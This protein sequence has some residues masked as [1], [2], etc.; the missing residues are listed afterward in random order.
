MAG[1]GQPAQPEGLH[2]GG[3]GPIPASCLEHQVGFGQ[4]LGLQAS[5]PPAL[6]PAR[7]G[8]LPGSAGGSPWKVGGSREGAERVVSRLSDDLSFPNRDEGTAG[9]PEASAG[10]LS[11]HLQQLPRATGNMVPGVCPRG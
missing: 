4:K 3:T 11:P 1:A 8:R 9:A 7:G 10:S 5:P 2:G 6:V